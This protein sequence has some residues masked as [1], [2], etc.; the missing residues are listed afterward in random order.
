MIGGRAL[1]ALG[2]VLLL[3]LLVGLVLGALQWW[4]VMP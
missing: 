2:H 1:L 4:G 3:G